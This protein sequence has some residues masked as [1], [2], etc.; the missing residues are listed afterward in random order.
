MT[1]DVTSTLAHRATANALWPALRAH[2]WR[3]HRQTRDLAS[4]GSHP[5]Y[6]SIGT[7][8][9]A[10]TPRGDDLDV[11]TDERYIRACVW[12]DEWPGATNL[13]IELTLDTYHHAL[14]TLT[15]ETATAYQHALQLA[16]CRAP[17]ERDTNRHGTPTLRRNKTDPAITFEAA[18]AL[19][20]IAAAANVHTIDQHTVD[21]ALLTDECIHLD[22]VERAT[23]AGIAVVV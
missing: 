4:N 21:D 3:R 9:I 6:R 18:R 15:P 2:R 23:G 14:S 16:T 7:G 10:N 17:F 11:I 22:Q 13:V 8:T 20:H 5:G 19:E 12:A 1:A